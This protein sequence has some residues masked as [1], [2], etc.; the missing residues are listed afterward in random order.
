MIE[1]II[2][3]T[4]QIVR[5]EG[6]LWAR[7]TYL[8]SKMMLILSSLLCNI[9]GKNRYIPQPAFSGT[10]AVMQLERQSG[11]WCC[12]DLTLPGMTGSRCWRD[13]AVR[14]YRW[15]PFRPRVK[16]KR[17]WRHYVEGWWLR[18]EAVCWC[19]RSISADRDRCY[20]VFA[21][22]LDHYRQACYATMDWSYG[23]RGEIVKVNG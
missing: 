11:R 15:R 8:L 9:L 4:L 6:S 20:V 17:R 21:G 18:H 13:G 12:P 23:Q 1:G 16:A 14:V 19:G 5:R 10:E 2:A 22:Q 3:C 7:D